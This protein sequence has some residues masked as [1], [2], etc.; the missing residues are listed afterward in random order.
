MKSKRSEIIIFLVVIILVLVS[1]LMWAILKMMDVYLDDLTMIAKLF[2]QEVEINTN[3]FERIN[4][5]ESNEKEK[6][7]GGK[8]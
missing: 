6:V 3:I 4:R 8:K 2:C 5:L 1:I 7:N